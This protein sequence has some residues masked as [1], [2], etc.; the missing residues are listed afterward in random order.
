MSAHIFVTGGVVS[1][2][3]KGLTSA[4]IG[5]LLENLGLRVRMQKLDPYLNVDAG[6]MNPF[7]HGEVYVTPDG[8]ET[9]L[10]LGHYERFTHGVIDRDSNFTA[11]RIYR[12]ILEKERR[13]DYLGGTV[14]VVPHVTNEIK[15]AIV[16][17]AGDDVD[18]VITE[19]GGTAGD[20]ESLPFLE[21][22]RQLALEVGRARSC[23]VHLTLV[24]YL[25]AAGEA[26]TKPSQHSVATLRAIGIQPDVLIC[27]TERPLDE[28]LKSK[29]ALFCNVS[30]PA[31]IEERDVETSIYEVPSVL[32]R[33]GLDDLLCRLLGLAA[34][35]P[36]DLTEW[37]RLV[38]VLKH[39]RATV[40]IAV[41]GKYVAH[42]DAY[43]SVY[44]GLTHAGLAHGVRV[45]VRKVQPEAIEDAGDAG[46]ETWLRG[47]HGILV[48]GGFGERGIEGKILAARYAREHGV[49]YYGL[50]L[51]LQIAV[52]EFARHVAGLAGA[53]STEFD[54]ATPHPVIH[55]MQAQRGV[56]SKGGTMRLG[57][58]ACRLAP[59]TRAAAAYGR[60]EVRERPRHRLEFNNDY[61][62]RLTSAGLVV[63]GVNP[64][65]DLVEI[66][67]LADHPWFVAAQFHPEF[68]SKP[69]APHPLFR[70]FVG[71]ALALAEGRRPTPGAPAR[72]GEASA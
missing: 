30:A 41:V 31:I 59:G 18:V 63:S 2:L 34:R 49:P 64:E 62:E 26:K 38:E 35:K 54:A 56:T 15:D 27:R 36:Q 14:Q 33:Q 13:G 69:T 28:G 23:F 57:A 65:L 8:A 6:T 22:C 60:A 20:I 47:A 52:V 48:P 37:D 71:A 66:V 3:G 5:C 68:Q 53:H 1:S 67:E 70:D 51:G 39:P 58:Y 72:V 17:V 29:L 44:E 61:R 42:H 55:L 9:D 45:K 10:D 25:R 46:P 32:H 40:E 19:I 50:C 7:Q 4:S 43:K 16:R 11:G 12:S 24:P 21:A